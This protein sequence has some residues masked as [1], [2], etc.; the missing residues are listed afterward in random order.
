MEFCEMKVR[1]TMLGVVV[2]V[3]GNDGKRREAKSE[4]VLL[5]ASTCRILRL[6]L[7]LRFASP[8]LP[9][10]RHPHPNPLLLPGAAGVWCALADGELR[11]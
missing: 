10:P 7:R 2:M 9:S 6:P 5:Y 3:G 1:V 4:G 11:G 8:P